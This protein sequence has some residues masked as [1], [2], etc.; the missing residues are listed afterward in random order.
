MLIKLCFLYDS[1]NAHLSLFLMIVFHRERKLLYLFG[2][3]QMQPNLLDHKV[4]MYKTFSYVPKFN[5]PHF[6]CLWD[7][8]FQVEN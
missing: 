4:C 8:G 5:N 2:L 3:K 1:L 7:S 6:C